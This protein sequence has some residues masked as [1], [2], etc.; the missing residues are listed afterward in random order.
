MDTGQFLNRNALKIALAVFVFAVVGMLVAGA[1]YAYSDSPQFCGSCHSM[2][3]P[4]ASWQESNHK[5]FKCTEC[6]LPQQN[7]ATKLVVK[8]QTGMNDTYHEVL[9]DYPATMVISP[10]GKAIVNDNCL[11]CHKSTVETTAMMTSGED[12]TKCHRGL[13]H[14]TNKSKGGIKVE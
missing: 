3:E 7:L 10:K 12:C 13:V 1:G 5:Q 4:T 2:V 14:G 11:R 6:H 8:A 9:R